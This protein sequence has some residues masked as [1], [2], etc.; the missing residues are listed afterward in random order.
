VEDRPG[1]AT[2]GDAPPAAVP[3]WAQEAIWYQIFVERFANGDPSNDPTLADMAGSWPHMAPEGWAP[4]PWGHPWFEQEA[5]AA[6][7]GE[8]FY[9]TVQLRRYGGDL[10][11][12]LDRLD[13]LEALGV[14]ALYLNPLNDA[15][16]LHKYDA[17]NYRHI[18][19]T[20]GP[21]P[22]G[23]ATRM[24]GEDPL[25]PAT[26][27]VTAADS[28][29]FALVAEA[30]R[31]GMRVVLDVSWNHTGVTFWAWRDVVEKG[32]ASPYADWYEIESFDD[33]ATP[34]VDEFSYRGWAGVAE[35]PELRK[36]GRPP[37]ET[38]GP[39]AG[40]LA[41]PVR[42]H[43]FA[44]TRRWLDPDGDGD[45][46]DGV[47]GF[48][49]DVAEMVPLGFWRE[50]RDSVKAIDPDAYLVGEVW[51]RDWPETMFDPAPWLQGDVFDAVMNYRWYQPT[52]S[53]FAGAP[54]SMGAPEELS[55]A[56]LAP[57]DAAG[58][59]AALERAQ[60]GIPAAH[61]KAQMN[62][63]A[64]HDAPRFAT[65]IQHPGPYKYRVNP[66]ENPGY[67]V[68]KPAPEVQRTQELILAQQFTWPGAPHIW[69]GD[70]VGMWGGDDPDTRKP[71][72]WADL[73]YADESGYPDGRSRRPDPVAPDTAWLG[74]VRALVQLR[75]EHTALLAHGEVVVHRAEPG[76]GVL[77]YERRLTGGEPGAAGAPVRRAL[78]AFNVGTTGVEVRLP[79][80][81]SAS[82]TVWRP[83]WAGPGW[84]RRSATV[85]SG[86]RVTLPGR[87]AVVWA[88]AG[89]VPPPG[90]TPST[91]ST[92]PAGSAG[93]NPG[94]R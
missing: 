3:V 20:F 28:L 74:R 91:G 26:W 88:A 12:V 93:A 14:T 50:Y 16:S 76:E 17:R 94:D 1:S 9:T 54:G 70:E 72:L 58:Y 4:T 48:R 18:D 63:V 86:T 87:S 21:D 41:E 83:L 75:R 40:T 67:G 42:R 62:L 90:S 5:W 49:L 43:V 11:G 68:T 80:A 7:T 71:M 25:D 84:R 24:A 32:A 27:L 73:T 78:V 53:F 38:H 52:R 29:F 59:V 45:P 44:V 46:S 79:G 23:D 56:D 6:A 64:S 37:G 61:V 33:P 69:Y 39:I 35:L 66:R 57:L 10:Q 47:D 82:G 8:P 81:G 77:V 15:P 2:P 89:A 36:V 19:R 60:A 30:H 92:A 55:D 13:H 85:A 51:W 34:D 31:R 65:S 22:A